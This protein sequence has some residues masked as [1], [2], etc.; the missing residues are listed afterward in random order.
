MPSLH[1]LAAIISTAAVAVA[2]DAPQYQGFTRDWQA[3]FSGS[4]GNLPSTRDWNI[5]TGDLGV[6]NEF[7]V[8]TSNPRNVQ[9]SGGNT[10]QLVPWR[11]N[12]IPKGWTSGRIESTYTFTPQAGKITRAEA[13]IRFGDNPISNKQGIWPAFWLLG[14]IIRHGGRWPACGELDIM[15]SV[16]GQLRGYGTAHCDVFPG[17]ICNEGQG[18]GN[19]IEIPDQSWHTWRIEID[20]QNGNWAAQTITWFRDGQQFHQITGSRIGNAGVWATLAQS[21]L[22]F[23]L[24]LAVGGDWPKPPNGA[25]LDGYGSMIEVGYVAQYSSASVASVASA[26]EEL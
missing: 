12:T 19:S 4:A 14:D 6:N 18:I 17:G 22:Y 26:H 5:R 15:E 11:D 10:L 3:T 13:A 21:P 25:T 24:N 23:I 7:Q 9:L 16:N 2:W 1:F 20:R 8:Y